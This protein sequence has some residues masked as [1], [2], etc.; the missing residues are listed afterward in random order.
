MCL[1]SNFRLVAPPPTHSRAATPSERRM[2][3]LL[4]P[5]RMTTDTVPEGAGST[6][7]TRLAP[8]SRLS[9][10][11][12]SPC[13]S[14]TSPEAPPRTSTSQGMRALS[15]TSAG[16]S[17]QQLSQSQVRTWGY[18]MVT[19]PSCTTTVGIQSP[20]Q[21]R[22]RPRKCKSA[23][24]TTRSAPFVNRRRPLLK[25]PSGAAKW[26]PLP[27]CSSGSVRGAATGFLGFIGSVSLGS[28]MPPLP[29]LVGVLRHLEELA[30]GPDSPRQLSRHGR[31]P[32]RGTE[33]LAIRSQRFFLQAVQLRLA[34]HLLA[35]LLQDLHANYPV[36]VRS[37]A[38]WSVAK[39]SGPCLWLYKGS[40]W[41]DIHQKVDQGGRDS[42]TRVIV[43]L[44]VDPKSS[45][46]VGAD[47]R[48]GRVF[49]NPGDGLLDQIQL[50]GPRHRL[51]TAARVE[52]AVDVIDMGL[53]G[54]HA[55]EELRR[56]L[57][58]GLADG[59][60][61]ENFELPLAQGFGKSCGR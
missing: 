43:A 21:A 25:E 56:D 22:Y 15:A 49:Q 26:L 50:P 9:E 40:G 53:D 44:L 60:E 36:H 58:V 20:K 19:V 16:R 8:P 6:T 27:P 48:R 7:S 59:Y 47:E 3:T 12:R 34:Q 42:C 52:L 32:P 45:A 10:P 61:L 51:C 57:A 46:L 2:A 31:G 28:S 29:V 4:A 41:R 38:L 39:P 18:R 33:S 37:S 35:L 55:D 24:M 54:A 14:A 13:R 1:S 23:R 17:D 11:S 30:E 5:P